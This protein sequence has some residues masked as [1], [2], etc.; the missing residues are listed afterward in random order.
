MM[1]K[2]VTRL[3]SQLHER[4]PTGWERFRLRAHLAVCTYC[5]RFDQQMAMLRETMRRYRS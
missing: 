2:D 4:K 5:S 3:I 1:C